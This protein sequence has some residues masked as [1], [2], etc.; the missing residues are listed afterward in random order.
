[1]PI[2]IALGTFLE[3]TEIAPSNIAEFEMSSSL[4]PNAGGDPITETYEL[5]HL[6]FYGKPS[7]FP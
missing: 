3:G 1:M 5:S 7:D 6:Q 2:I 4:T